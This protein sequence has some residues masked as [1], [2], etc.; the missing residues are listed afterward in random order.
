MTTTV[1]ADNVNGPLLARTGWEY[2]PV[3]VDNND[4]H[5]YRTTPLIHSRVILVILTMTNHIFGIHDVENHEGFRGIKGLRSSSELRSCGYST[6]CAL[7]SMLFIM[8][9]VMTRQ[10][11]TENKRE[12]LGAEE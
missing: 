5:R 8:S 2:S 1:S 6:G 3:V 4:N 10:R 11:L 12:R 9:L 7:G